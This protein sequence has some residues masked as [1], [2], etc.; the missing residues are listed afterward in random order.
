MTIASDQANGRKSLNRILVVDDEKDINEL[1]KA[2]L[3]SNGFRVDA[4][5]DSQNALKYFRLYP[6]EYS[7]VLSDINMPIIN[8]FQLVKEIESINPDVKKILMSASFID[9]NEIA[10]ALQSTKI[11]D[12]LQKPFTLRILK[13]VITKHMVNG[14]AWTKNY[15]LYFGSRF[16]HSLKGID[17]LHNK[18]LQFYVN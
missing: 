14:K 8:G 11:D 7:L 4:F 15:S 16:V 9:R 13:D 3:E 6:N 18:S 5:T 12:F 1:V 10:Q 17:S 2:A